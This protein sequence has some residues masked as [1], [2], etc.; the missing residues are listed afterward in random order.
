MKIKS[1]FDQY[2]VLAFPR[3]FK[4]LLR[5]GGVIFE[6]FYLLKYAIN[7]RSVNER[8]NEEDYSN[9]KELTNKDIDSI[10]FVEE[11]K[12][13]LYKK[14]LESGNY[15]CYAIISNGHFQYL[16][17]ISWKFMNYPIFFNISEELDPSQA[18]LEDSYC[19]PEYRGKGLH[20]KMNIFRLKKI[21][22][23]GKTEVLALVLK[24]NKGALRVQEK[25]G[26]NYFSRIRFIK[27]NSWIKIFKKQIK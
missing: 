15:S 7:E 12:I 2:G 10:D 3:L 13:L 8:F 1:F 22:E 14:R 21:L 16:T 11:K 5:K 17:W 27:I 26:F 9:V 6:T 19:K 18:L 25:S 24:E 23:K 20:S 4:A